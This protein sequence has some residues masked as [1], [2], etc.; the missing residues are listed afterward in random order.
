MK[1]SCKQLRQD[2]A[3][4]N[5]MYLFLMGLLFISCIS[6]AQDMQPLQTIRDAVKT[7]LERQIIDTKHPPKITLGRLDSRLRLNA[8]TTPL[9]IT[10]PDEL[11]A[12]RKTVSVRCPS[13]SWKIYLPVNI[14][15]YDEVLV[16][17]HPLL[18]GTTPQKSDLMLET[19]DLGKLSNGYFQNYD[20][21]KQL[22]VRRAIKPGQVLNPGLLKAKKLVKNGQI[23]TIIANSEGIQVRS[24]GKALADGTAGQQI[25]IRNL[26]SKRVV[27]GTVLAQGL[28]QINTW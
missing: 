18:R 12:G 16:A 27:E 20:Q 9:I 24:S 11:T 2:R 28:V 17:K 26:S 6:S 13:P 25:K 5:A 22:I 23:V 10:A 15:I 4:V 19:R 3:Y 1:I 8:C 7:Q 21:L 14:S